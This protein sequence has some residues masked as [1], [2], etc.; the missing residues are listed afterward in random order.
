MRA[1]VPMLPVEPRMRTRLREAADIEEVEI[2]DWAGP[3]ER[4]DE[5]EGTADAW[6]EGSGVLDGETALEDGFGE[7]ADDADGGEDETEDGDVGWVEER[8]GLAEA[9]VDGETGD[10]CTE[11]SA[12]EAF[13]CFTGADVRDHLVLTDEGA[14]GVGTA[15]SHFGDGD[16]EENVGDPGETT[17]GGVAEVEEEARHEAPAPWDVE[18]AE[19]GPCDGPE[20]V[21]AVE[22]TEERREEG[23]DGD[24]GDEAEVDDGGPWVTGSGGDGERADRPCETEGEEDPAPWGGDGG[25][26]GGVFATGGEA[27]TTEEDVEERV[28]AD[29]DG[30]D[31]EAPEGER[32]GE[33]AQEDGF[34]PGGCG[35]GRERRSCGRHVGVGLGGKPG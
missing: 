4:V 20:R 28:G 12:K 32:A 11:G 26:H 18:E 17:V 2:E 33:A 31:D 9:E 24:G 8:E 23:G 35:R 27:E 34:F 25:V 15:V 10:E 14:D 29:G 7:I 1:L 5:V 13:P 16:D 3:E 21:A 6:E 30:G 22:R 19:D